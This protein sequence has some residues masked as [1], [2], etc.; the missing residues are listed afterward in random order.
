MRLPLTAL[1]ATLCLAGPALAHQKRAVR[2]A[3]ASA[4]PVAGAVALDVM[5]WLRFAGERAEAFRA[6]F[7]VDRSGRFEPAEAALAG[8]SLAPEVI[9][10]FFVRF[11]GAARPPESAEAKARMADDDAIEVAVLLSW[12][13]HAAGSVQL[14]SRAGRDREG[15]PVIMARFAALPP[16]QLVAPD[17]PLT[18][19]IAGPAPLLPGAD[20]L[21]VKLT[22]ADPVPLPDGP[23]DPPAAPPAVPTNAPSEVKP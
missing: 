21:T 14:A 20:G 3:A 8:N 6:R 23:P 12:A 9:G 11:D 19:G 16:L 13:P 7:D 17:P 2:T 1:I 15:A 5:L 10:G 18:G 4:R 22:L